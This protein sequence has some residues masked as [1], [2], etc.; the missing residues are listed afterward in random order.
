MSGPPSVGH[1]RAYSHPIFFHRWVG[2]I[3][4]VLVCGFLLTL[5]GLGD[6]YLWPFIEL[7]RETVDFLGCRTLPCVP[8]DFGMGF[9]Y[10]YV[11][12]VVLGAAVRH[13]R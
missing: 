3:F 8:L 7:G 13:V 1:N 4:F 6:P 9:V 5:V 11:V 10:M 12:A 2:I